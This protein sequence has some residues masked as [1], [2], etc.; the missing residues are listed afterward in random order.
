MLYVSGCLGLAPDSDG[1]FAM[2]DGELL[3]LSSLTSNLI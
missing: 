2:V 1:K 3:S